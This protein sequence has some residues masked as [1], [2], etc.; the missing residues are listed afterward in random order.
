MGAYEKIQ[1]W[2]GKINEFSKAIPDFNYALKLNQ[3]NGSIYAN[4]GIAY[5][6]TGKKTEACQDWRKASKM[7]IGTAS[8][9]VR[10]YCR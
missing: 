10:R 7:G 8:V 4:R 9:Y 2:N 6:K 3:E 5:Y 1:E